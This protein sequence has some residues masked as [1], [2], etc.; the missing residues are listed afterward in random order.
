MCNFFWYKWNQYYQ[1]N[2]NL[3]HKFDFYG[4]K[5]WNLIDTKPDVPRQGDTLNCGVFLCLFANVN[6]KGGSYQ[7]LISNVVNKRGQMYIMSQIVSQFGDIYV[8]M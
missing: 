2:D 1:N 7:S 4:N 5:T 6:A 8:K 3:K